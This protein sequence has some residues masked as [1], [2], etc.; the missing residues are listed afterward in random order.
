MVF[1]PKLKPIDFER[2][3]DAVGTLLGRTP[4]HVALFSTVFLWFWLVTLSGV[5]YS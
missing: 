1:R 3:H 5:A 4:V 2:L